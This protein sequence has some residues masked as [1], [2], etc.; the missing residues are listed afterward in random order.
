MSPK[1]PNESVNTQ[2]NALLEF[3][4]SAEYLEHLNQLKSYLKLSDTHL[5]SEFSLGINVRS[6]VQYKSRHI[7][8]L[9]VALWQHLSL[10]ESETIYFNLM[11][12]P[13]KNWSVS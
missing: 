10:N 5:E 6:L 1:K 3:D 8:N 13:L 9:L 4:S 2:L 12:L 11:G 7:D